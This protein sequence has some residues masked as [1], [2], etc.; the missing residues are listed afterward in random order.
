MHSCPDCGQAC[1]CSGDIDDVELE[2]GE[3][4]CVCECDKEGGDEPEPDCECVRTDVDMYDAGGCPLH[5]TSRPRIYPYNPFPAAS[6]VT[7]GLE[8]GDC[9]F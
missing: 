5:G 7:E 6:A 3:E 4:G 2:G 9:P 8:D 1:Y